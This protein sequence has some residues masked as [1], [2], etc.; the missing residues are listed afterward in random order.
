MRIYI[1]RH[2]WTYER[3]AD[4]W[5]DDGLRPLTDEGIDRFHKMA[6]TLAKRGFAPARVATSPLVRCRQTAEIL[7]EY[8]PKSTE[9]V[10]L[11]ALA[12]GSD[13]RAALEWSRAVEADVVWVGHS[14]DVE[15][16]TAQ[17]IGDG[18]T[19]IRFAKGAAAAIRFERVTASQ[20]ELEWLVTA[21]MLGI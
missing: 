13:L 1:V 19:S 2:A 5:P 16:L 17:L 14:P 3:D 12:P 7:S 18:Q 20:G 8:L 6:K 11:P 9:L 15:E 10:E 21:K 4:R